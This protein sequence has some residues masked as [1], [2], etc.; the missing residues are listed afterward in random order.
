MRNVGRSFC[1]LGLAALM[2][3]APSGLAAGEDLEALA[4]RLKVQCEG[5]CAGYMREA[6]GGSIRATYE[7]AA[8]TCMCFLRG[9]PADYTG[10]NNL[11]QCA[12]DNSREARKLG[13]TAPILIIER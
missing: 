11:K 13:S 6:N 12:I 1:F 9:V 3:T 4:Q 5:E 10:R 7:A 8:C 2:A